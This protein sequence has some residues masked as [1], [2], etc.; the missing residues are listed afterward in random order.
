MADE[1]RGELGMTSG[2]Q[3]SSLT[4]AEREA[5][6]AAQQRVGLERNRAAGLVGERAFDPWRGRYLTDAEREAVTAAG[7]GAATLT[8]TPAA[9]AENPV[10]IEG[11]HYWVRWVQRSGVAHWTPAHFE[12]GSWWLVGVP[13]SVDVRAV[14]A[15]RGP[16]PKPAEPV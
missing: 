8:F 14:N 15:W 1:V 2:M 5:R 7:P 16:I 6:Y 10:P 11:E 13:H 9:L 12:G 4:Q 3:I